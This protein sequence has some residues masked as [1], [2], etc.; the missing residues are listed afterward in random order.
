MLCQLCRSAIVGVLPVL[1]LGAI[2]SLWHLPLFFIA[3]TLQSRIPFPLF[4]LSTIALSIL[5]AWLFNRTGGSVI[6]VL[7]LHTAVNAWAWVIPVI[8]VGD[9]RPYGLAVGLL[10]LVALS[11]LSNKANR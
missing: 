8:V 2:W 5:L 7:V 1:V 11:L 3:D 6:P 10:V 4:M 9:R